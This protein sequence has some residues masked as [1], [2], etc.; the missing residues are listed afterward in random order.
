MENT[1]TQLMRCP[2][3]WTRNNP[4]RSILL[5]AARVQLEPEVVDSSGLVSTKGTKEHEED[6]T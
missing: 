5:G 2:T 6:K 1:W 4:R 3:I